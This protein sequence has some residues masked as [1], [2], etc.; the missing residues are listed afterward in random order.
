MCQVIAQDAKLF[1]M[2]FLG[3]FSAL[4]RH[5]VEYVLIGGLATALHGVEWPDPST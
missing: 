5:Q 4:D 3:L 1:R 2:F